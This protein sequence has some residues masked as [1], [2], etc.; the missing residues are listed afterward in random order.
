MLSEHEALQILESVLLKT[1]SLNV[2]TKPHSHI[3]DHIHVYALALGL[4]V[5]LPGLN[6]F[7]TFL[8]CTE[9]IESVLFYWSCCFTVHIQTAA[10]P[11]NPELCLSL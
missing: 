9:S 5:I 11:H 3:Q 6:M 2:I 4:F 8:F 1:S 10:L 7:K